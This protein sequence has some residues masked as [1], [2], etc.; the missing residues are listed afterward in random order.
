VK[1]CGPLVKKCRPHFEKWRPHFEKWRPHFGK[2]RPHF[3]KWRPQRKI[4]SLGFFLCDPL[5]MMIGATKHCSDAK[6]LKISLGATKMNAGATKI[7]LT[8]ACVY[9]READNCTESSRVGGRESA[10]LRSALIILTLCRCDISDGFVPG[11]PSGTPRW[12]RA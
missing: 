4:S 6:L 12:L 3:K 7:S 10:Y 8:R 11:S 5:C 2:R 1:K 9:A